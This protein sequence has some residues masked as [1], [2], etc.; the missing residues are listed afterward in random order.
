ML[1][2]FFYEFARLLALYSATVILFLVITEAFICLTIFFYQDISIKKLK[3]LLSFIG[4]AR[5]LI[6]AHLRRIFF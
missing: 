3:N 1:L 6:N 4:D 2:L 5:E